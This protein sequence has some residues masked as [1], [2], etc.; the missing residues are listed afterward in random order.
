MKNTLKYL[1]QRILGYHRYLIWFAHYKIHTLHKDVHEKD[2]FYFLSL[3]NPEKGAILDI[4]ANIGI[5]TYHLSKRFPSTS[6]FAFEPIQS[7]VEA[8]KKIITNYKLSNVLL[9]PIA[10]GNETKEVEMVLP[11]QRRAKLQG[12]SHVK[13]ESITEWNEGDVVQVPMKTLDEILSA[14]PIS[15]IKMDVENFEYFVLQGGVA[16][17]KKNKPVI[18][19]ELWANLNREHCIEMLESLGYSTYILFKNNLVAYTPHYQHHQN[20]IFIPIET[21]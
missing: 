19:T 10:L 4:G 16:L 18:Y 17:I 12:L 21:N 2:F 3:I 6:I 8:L 15:A 7:N 1:F 20:F 11:I 9:Y 14:E 5:M 13:H